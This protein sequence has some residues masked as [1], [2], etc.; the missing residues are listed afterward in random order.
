MF[1]TQIEVQF[2]NGDVWY[3]LKNLYNAD[4]IH[5]CETEEAYYLIPHR[6]VTVARV[7]VEESLAMMKQAK[8]L[9]REGAADIGKVLTFKN[10]DAE[11]KPAPKVAWKSVASK[12]KPTKQ[13]VCW[14][15]VK[16]Q[17]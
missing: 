10:V 3:E 12:P 16:P 5:Y 8:S 2:K 6:D 17:S 13:D 9:P 11:D 15:E 14:A 4:M 7:S 1:T